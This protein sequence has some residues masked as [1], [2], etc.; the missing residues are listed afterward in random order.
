[1][2]YNPRLNCP[3]SD[4]KY[5]NSS[6]NPYVN[7]GYGMFQNNGNC[8]C[9]V[10]GRFM[11]VLGQDSCNLCINDAEDFYNHDDDYKRGQKP[12][13]GAIICW[14]G[15]GSLAG[16]V[17]VVEEIKEDGTIITSNSAWRSSLFY[18]KELKPP[19]NMGS[20]Y[21]LQGF[22]YNP[23]V[24]EEPEPEPTGE[25][26]YVNSEDGLWLLDS[27]GSKIKAYPYKTKVNFISNGYD[28]YGYH[29]YKVKVLEDGKIGYMAS[30]Y[31]TKE[32][33][34]PPQPEPTPTPAPSPS[35]EFHIGERVLVT[36]Y[37]TE[38]SYGGGE[39]TA[40]YTGNPND[41]D[42]IRFITD[43]NPNAPRPYHISVGNTLGEGDRGWVSKDQISRI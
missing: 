7:A 4:N 5:Y 33:P 31:L 38:D 23:A 22:I 27:N 40:D 30:T 18:I 9:Y 11:E 41:P 1:M 12:R 28:R 37:A 21:E 19:Y 36:G 29:Y 8:T 43:I 35:D 34:T 20:N 14:E 13:L 26:Y 10:Y 2:N 17:A 16:H 6:I 39:Q 25:I 15:K 32:Q 42:D 3:S 24:E